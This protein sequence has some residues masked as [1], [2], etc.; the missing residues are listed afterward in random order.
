MSTALEVRFLAGRFHATPW[1]SH[2]NEGAIEWPPAPWRLFRALVAAGAR[3]PG[4]TAGELRGILGPFLDAPSYHLPPASAAHARYWMPWEKKGPADRTKI[5]DAFVAL[6]R[7]SPMT[8]V[9]PE[10]APESD[11]L[12]G[13]LEGLGYLGRSQSWAELRRVDSYPEPDVLP[14]GE[15]REA[16]EDRETVSLLAPDPGTPNETLRGA[17]LGTS[18]LHRR[19]LSVPPGTR[20]V[21]Y[22]RPP[23]D[24]EPVP[25]LRRRAKSPTRPTV[26]RYLLEGPALP[27]LTE[28]IT[29][30]DLL[31]RSAMAQFGRREQGRTSS[32]LSGKDER[33]RP[34]NGHRHAFYFATD[35]DGDRRIDHLTVVAAEGFG[36][37]ER[38]ALRSVRVLNPGRE[39]PE[40]RPFLL[41]LGN[42]GDFPTP[43]VG[44]GRRW[45]SHTPF[46]LIRH[47]KVRG[48]TSAGK[49]LVDSPEHQVR[50]ELVRRGFPEPVAV[51]PLRSARWLE[52][53]RHRRGHESLGWAYGFE[54]EFDAEV[55][56]PIALGYGCHFGLGLFLPEASM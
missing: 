42:A 9:W 36:P 45:R 2:V 46:V 6:D 32:V 4:M 24:L 7:S 28:A 23:L 49:R 8:V 55:E 25:R 27:P 19:G 47:P 18:E 43:L 11:R 20:W 29:M 33:G 16:P 14:L 44:S 22:A 21:R 31:R 53:R 34:L 13:V 37:E 48:T 12:D 26:A 40:V 56:G 39:R 54:L 50:L 1:G 38:D 35:E 5:V 51:R 3:T 41:G 15:G 17:L 10:D 52:F 30:C